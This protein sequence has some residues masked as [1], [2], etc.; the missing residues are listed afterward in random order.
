MYKIKERTKKRINLV[1]ATQISSKG[2]EMAN[3]GEY[4]LTK[5][6]YTE[7]P[8]GDID[9]ALN[10]LNSNNIP[11]P[12]YVRIHGVESVIRGFDEYFTKET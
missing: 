4:F 8:F 12:D 7:K 10:F 6:N 5:E 11:E 1:W 2:F 3:Q 9:F